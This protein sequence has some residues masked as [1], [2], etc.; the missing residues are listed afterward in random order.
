MDW[1]NGTA[2]GARTWKQQ[3]AHLELQ[4]ALAMSVAVFSL[5][6]GLLAA[7]L[8]IAVCLLY[9]IMACLVVAG[10]LLTIK[11]HIP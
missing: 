8:T 6:C 4:G 10:A 2:V 3:H 1:H 9:T 5:A 11:Q 7:A